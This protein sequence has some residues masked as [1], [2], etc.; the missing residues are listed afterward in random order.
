[1]KTA[2]SADGTDLAFDELG[3]GPPIISWGFLRSAAAALAAALPNG[4]RRTLADQTHDINPDATAAA[5]I[6]LL[7][8]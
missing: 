3:D 1:M 2:R 4:Q 6:E 7:A 5:L 8:S